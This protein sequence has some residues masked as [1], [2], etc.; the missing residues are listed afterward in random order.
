[1]NS[2]VKLVTRIVIVP[3]CIYLVGELVT[4]KIIEAVKKR[5]EKKKK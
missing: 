1:M 3:V 2:I 5:T 4:P